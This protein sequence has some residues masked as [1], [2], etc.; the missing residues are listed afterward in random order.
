MQIGLSFENVVFYLFALVLLAFIAGILTKQKKMP[1]KMASKLIFNSLFGYV[2]LLLTN[3]I[4]SFFGL[5]IGVNMLSSFL[6]GI[7]GIPG[8][9]LLLLLQ[10]L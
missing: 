10:F 5:S 3:F 7:L 8:V 6:V 1:Y 2:L 4:L 9:F